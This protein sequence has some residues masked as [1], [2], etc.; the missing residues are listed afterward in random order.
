MPPPTRNVPGRTGSP[1][2][3]R[4][5]SLMALAT[6]CA[7]GLQGFDASAQTPTAEPTPPSPEVAASPAPATAPAK[8]PAEGV[9]VTARLGSGVTVRSGDGRFS[10]TLRGRSQLL[11][12]ALSHSPGAEDGLASFQVRRMR[13]V[14]QGNLFGEDWQYYM[15]LAFANRDTESDLRLPLRDAWLNWSGLRDLN[16]RF[17]QMKVPHDRQ[18]V[19]SSSSLQFPD[20][21]LAT[22]EFNLDRDVGLQLFS[23]D[24][25]GADHRFGYN[26]AI[27][28]GDGRNRTGTNYG[29]LYVAR[30]AYLPFGKFDD[31]IEGDLTRNAE[32]RLALAVSGAYNQKTVRARSTLDSTYRLGA[33]DYLHATADAM[34][35]YR[36]FS[37]LGQFF[38]RDVLGTRERVDATNPASPVTETSRTGFGYFGQA[39]YMMNEN[40]E[41]VARFSEV[42][43]LQGVPTGIS[44]EGELGGGLNWYVHQHNF[45][46]QADYFWL[47]RGSFEQGRHQFRFQ[48]QFAL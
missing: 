28:G 33:Y 11:F 43:P 45:K 42:R 14:M 6:V 29:L 30:L 7:L 44:F 32:P 9:D 4:L 22:I 23:N 47:Y 38:Y 1:L 48:A 24:L 31:F 8:K 15:Q 18:R 39:G 3:A 19:I 46:F 36:G 35:K 10:L 21:A 25:G 16:V 26:L 34:F 27:F 37:F 20:R 13:L 17:G 40:L 12:T 2:S 5:A 41:A